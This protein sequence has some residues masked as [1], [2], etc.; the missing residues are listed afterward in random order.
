MEGIDLIKKVIKT[1]IETSKEVIEAKKSDGIS[2][3]ELLG[4][5]DNVI[6]IGSQLLRYNKIVAQIKD[7]DSSEAKAIVSYVLSFGIASGDVQ[8]IIDHSFA[9]IQIQ[10]DAYNEHLKPIIEI[11]KEMKK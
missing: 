10:I 9:Y 4:L 3:M 11:V 2:K 8:L 1:V 5:G 7:V 6:S